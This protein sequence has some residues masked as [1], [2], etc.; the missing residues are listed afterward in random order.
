[1]FHWKDRSRE[2]QWLQEHAREYAD[3]WVALEGE[4]LVEHGA[5]GAE[6]LI[7]AKE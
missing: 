7:A 4:Q 2:Y 1:V 5:N 3:Q 6:V